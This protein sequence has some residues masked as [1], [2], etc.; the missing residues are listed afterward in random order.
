MRVK[1]V[2]NNPKLKLNLQTSLV[3]GIF[4]LLIIITLI[5]PAG[6]EIYG[7]EIFAGFLVLIA[8]LFAIEI[9]LN[10]KDSQKINDLFL[11]IGLI[12]ILWEIITRLALVDTNLLQPPENV[13][14]V[15]AVDYLTILTG[16]F[17]S[18]SILSLGYIIAVASA[19]PIGLFMGWKKRLHNVAYPTAKALGPIPPT[20]YIPYAIALLPSFFASSVFVIFIGAFWPILVGVVGGVYNIDHRLI[21]SAR[22]LGLN[23]TTIM[24]KVLLPGALPSIFQG[25][26]IGLIIS[27]IT[28]MVAEII[29]SSAGLG[30]YLQSQGQFANYASVMAGMIVVSIVVIFVT[31]IFDRV[32]NYALRWQKAHN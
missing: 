20:V 6:S 30:W 12:I 29:G 3:F 15:Y 31:M 13:F 21:N 11:L 32:Q 16:I 14:A 2:M 4:L 10:R 28:L 25:A 1:N 27:F 24:W 19:I 23:N 9:Y 18:L 5:S 8:F 22:T 26:L 17:S 7:K